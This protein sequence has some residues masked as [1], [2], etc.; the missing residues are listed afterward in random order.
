MGYKSM[1]LQRVRH[2]GATNTFTFNLQ[3]KEN[4]KDL[5]VSYHTEHI[6]NALQ[7]T[8]PSIPGAAA[9]SLNPQP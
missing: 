3:S 4:Q 7:P 9:P 8:L 1:G 2:D 5:G 6:L